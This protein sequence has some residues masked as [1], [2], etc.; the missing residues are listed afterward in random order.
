MSARFSFHGKGRDILTK[1]GM[2]GILCLAT[3]ILAPLA[4]LFTLRWMVANIRTPDGKAF[5]FNGEANEIYSI[6]VAGIFLGSLHTISGYLSPRFG[7]SNG[8]TTWYLYGLLCWVIYIFINS[9]IGYWSAIAYTLH[10]TTSE[11]GVI[12]ERKVPIFKFAVIDTF[13]HFSIYTVIGGPL[14]ACWFTRWICR[15]VTFRGAAVD[16]H[17]EGLEMLW[18]VIVAMIGCIPIVTIPWVITWYLNW[19]VSA[20]SLGEN[21]QDSQTLPPVIAATCN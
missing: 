7:I 10:N 12:F 2:L 16:F 17:G 11:D 8:S 15:H 1:R 9:Y 18:R 3:L 20:F 6:T 21:K 13:L 19:C 4:I 14:V 5:R